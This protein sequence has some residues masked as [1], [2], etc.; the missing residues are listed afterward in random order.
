MKQ[1]KMAPL[2]SGDATITKQEIDH[3]LQLEEE[4]VKWLQDRVKQSSEMTSGEIRF[5]KTSQ[6]GKV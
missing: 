5:L 1:I 3:K 6:L 4:N 2:V